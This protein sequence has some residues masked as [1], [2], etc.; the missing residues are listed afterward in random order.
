MAS[1]RNCALLGGFS[2]V[3]LPLLRLPPALSTS[4]P[5]HQPARLLADDH[6]AAEAQHLLPSCRAPAC[7]CVRVPSVEA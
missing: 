5:L 4:S 7:S 3:E 6:E 1:V 2:S